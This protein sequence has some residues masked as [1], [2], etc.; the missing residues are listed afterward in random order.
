MND[1]NEIKDVLNKCTIACSP[2]KKLLAGRRMGGS[3]EA[4]SVLADGGGQLR[5]VW[6]CCADSERT[7]AG[8]VTAWLLHWRS[9]EDHRS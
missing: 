1:S 5:T 7:V 8:A 4:R 2:E 6:R 3:L 9:V